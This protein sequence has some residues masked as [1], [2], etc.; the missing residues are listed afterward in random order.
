[1]GFRVQDLGLRRV[2]GFCVVKTL[3]WHRQFRAHGKFHTEA[4]RLS[5]GIGHIKVSEGFCLL[6]H[7]R[8][9]APKMGPPKKTSGSPV[10]ITWQKTVRKPF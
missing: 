9:A 6:V 1:M 8:F 7:L 3:I 10:P 5:R 4:G 2:K